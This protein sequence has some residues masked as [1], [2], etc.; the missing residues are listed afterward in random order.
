M[1]AEMLT[2]DLGGC[3]HGTYG[4]ACCPAH[5]DKNPSFSIRDG[6]G[7]N[8]LTHCFSGCSPEAVW[9]ALRDRGLVAQAADRPRERHHRRRPQR[10]DKPTPEPSPNQ[11]HALDN[12]HSARPAPGTVT[13]TYLRH[14]SITC[15]IPPTIRDHP[16]LKHGPTGQNLRAMVVAITGADRKVIAVQRTF[17]RVDGRGKANVSQPK[18]T[19]GP[20]RDGAVRLGPAGLV[21][22]IAEGVESGLSA[23]QLFVLP[24][25]CSLSAS[26]LDRLWLPP[27]AREVHIFGDNGTPGHEAAERAARAYQAQGCQVFLRFPPKD[28]GDWND[29]LQDRK[30]E[31][32]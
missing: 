24:V 6:D 19:L 4:I 23:M 14:R 25:W 5:E 12:W 26:R 20:M 11:D 18:L 29:Y 27:E 10:P 28:I 8:L 30:T 7:G 13:A 16:G 21:L 3:W 31:A 1:N 17:L 22:G 15:A 2:K 9:A 32:A